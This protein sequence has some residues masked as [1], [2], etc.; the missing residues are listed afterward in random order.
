M[1]DSTTSRRRSTFRMDNL[2]G[3]S[4]IVK[5]PYE[6]GKNFQS[7]EVDERLFDDVRNLLAPYSGESSRQTTTSS[8]ARTYFGGKLASQIVEAYNH[9][10]ASGMLYGSEWSQGIIREKNCG[11]IPKH[12]LLLCLLDRRFAS[13]G[14]SNQVLFT[15]IVKDL[16]LWDDVLTAMKQWKLTEKYPHT[17]ACKSPLLFPSN[18]RVQCFKC[19]I[20]V[21]RVWH[22]ARLMKQNLNKSL[23]TK[24]HECMRILESSARP[25]TSVQTPRPS[26]SSDTG[27]VTSTKT[28]PP[29]GVPP[30]T[31]PSQ[32]THKTQVATTL[33]SSEE[34]HPNGP[35]MQR[36]ESNGSSQNDC[37][38][39][40]AQKQWYEDRVA[41]RTTLSDYE[42][43][44][45]WYPMDPTELILN[46][47][48]I[49][50]AWLL[51]ET[52]YCTRKKKISWTFISELASPTLQTQLHQ[53]L[54]PGV[55]S[56]KEDEGKL[57]KLVRM[58][59]PVVQK[60]FAAVRIDVRKRLLL[61]EFRPAV[62][63]IVPQLRRAAHPLRIK[64]WKAKLKL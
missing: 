34:S 33:S 25:L 20:F 27:S 17:A 42:E 53:L 24:I 59:Y 56:A 49:E 15:V 1:T 63:V 9:I 32:D 26:I 48:E 19:I 64:K 60:R 3:M 54:K 45:Y 41:H 14:K 29:I 10:E 50:L 57:S 12:V 47:T 46:P 23:R 7:A 52:I 38:V 44:N 18:L 16:K 13:A 2:I 30:V 40:M 39:N 36:T 37:V 43:K 6:G 11:N 58:H 35:P 31:S 5:S 55:E 51:E 21:C 62:R 28:P 22:A 4:K 8:A 61:Q